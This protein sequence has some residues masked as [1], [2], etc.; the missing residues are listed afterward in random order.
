MSVPNSAIGRA[1][2]LPPSSTTAAAPPAIQAV[3]R[4]ARVASVKAATIVATG[5]GW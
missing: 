1:T 5:T 2:R 4:G 3:R